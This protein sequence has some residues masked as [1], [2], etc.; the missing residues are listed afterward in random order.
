MEDMQGEF[1]EIK[2]ELEELTEAVGKISKALIGDLDNPNGL[3][4]R[5]AQ[6]QAEI[7]AV[8]AKLKTSERRVEQVEDFVDMIKNRAIGISIGLTFASGGLG[9]LISQLLN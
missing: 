3:V 9:A 8:K 5:I 2:K 6:Q 4:S 7:E 1:R